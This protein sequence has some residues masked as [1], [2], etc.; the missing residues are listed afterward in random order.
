MVLYGNVQKYIT[1]PSPIHKSAMLELR[2]ILLS[3]YWQIFHLNSP[4]SYHWVHLYS[5]VERMKFF[6]PLLLHH[7]AALVSALILQSTSTLSLIRHCRKCRDRAT[8]DAISYS[9]SFNVLEYWC[10]PSI[11][12]AS[13]AGW[14]L[15]MMETGGS[16]TTAFSTTRRPGWSKLAS[17]TAHKYVLNNIVQQYEIHK[18]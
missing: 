3:T 11:Q 8:V 9:S 5:S 1:T 13:Q 10:H 15:T 12:M 6:P 14:S 16:P 2:G 7:H 18:E 17:T 4:I